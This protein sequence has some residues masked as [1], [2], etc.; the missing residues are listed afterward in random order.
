M[1][2]QDIV[3][4]LW[5]VLPRYT[6][7]F[8]DN[9]A[10]TS[11]TRSSAIVTAVTSVDHGL[12]TGAYVY[13][14]GAI[15]PITINSLT[16]SGNIATAIT[17]SNHDYTQGYQETVNITGADQSQ[18]NGSH[19][20]LTV[21]NRRT[22]TFSITGN[23]ES[24][25][26]GT[27]IQTI[28][29]IKHGYNGLYQITK[30]DDKT[31]TYQITSLPESP[32]LGTIYAQA[33]IRVTGANSIQRATE[34]YTKQGEGQLYAFVV[35]DN[36]TASKDRYTFNDGTKTSTVGADFRQRIIEPFSIYVFTPTTREVGGLN[37]R[38]LMQDL[39]SPIFKSILR[40][41][42]PSIFADDTEFK[43]GFVGHQ[44]IE[45]S[46]AYYIHEFK[47]ENQF[48]LCYDDTIDD[49]D[50]VAFRDIDLKFNSYLNEQ[51]NLIMQTNVDLDDQ[52]LS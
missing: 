51:H 45:Y 3:K 38:D 32:A 11:L 21:P 52:P 44:F 5:L 35:L 4:Q 8:S 24:P 48:D 6:N 41:H 16:Q 23:P 36:I 50:S 18:Y 22:F 20:L 15:T 9:I 47:F 46:P 49:D 29:N 13:I 31:F 28:Q 25:A 26:A 2:A 42:F 12:S 43:I 40:C 34:M 10:I 27:L 14:S 17:N 37:A 1:K 19:P 39:A 7:L 30:I 33:N